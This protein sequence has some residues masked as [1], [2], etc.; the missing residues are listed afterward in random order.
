MG[1]SKIIKVYS[2]FPPLGSGYLVFTHNIYEIELAYCYT[3]QQ[4][5][6]DRAVYKEGKRY[7]MFSET[8]DYVLKK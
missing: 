2:V 1:K 6:A 5:L 8:A 3:I 7:L 4:K